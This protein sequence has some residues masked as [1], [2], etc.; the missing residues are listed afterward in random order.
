MMHFF[1][2]YAFSSK[3]KILIIKIRKAF[4]FFF[5]NALFH[6]KAVQGDISANSVPI[7]LHCSD[8]LDYEPNTTKFKNFAQK[9]KN[10]K[11]FTWGVCRVAGP[12]QTPSM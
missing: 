12:W 6:V 7:T 10:V 11:N 8:V 4:F 1:L 9:N 5:L 3:C 2:K